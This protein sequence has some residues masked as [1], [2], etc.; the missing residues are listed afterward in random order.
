MVQHEEDP[1]II[2]LKVPPARLVIVAC[3]CTACCL[4][5]GKFPA[6]K[7]VLLLFFGGGGLG[8]QKKI[9][10]FQGRGL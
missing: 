2:K 7:K 8:G 1:N 5:G 6:T 3:D 9:V 10:V 4:Y